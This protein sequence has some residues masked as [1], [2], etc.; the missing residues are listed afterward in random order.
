MSLSFLWIVTAGIARTANTRVL[1]E[2]AAI[3]HGEERT[4]RLNLRT[5][6]A[7]QFLRVAL[8]WIGLAVYFASAFISALLTSGDQ[9]HTAAFLFLFLAMFVT[10]AAI[11]SFFNWILLLAPIYALRDGLTLPRAMLGAWQL[12]RSR[13]GSLFGLNLAHLALRLVWFVFMS[14]VAAIPMGFVQILPKFVVFLAA[15]ASTMLYC[16]GA[17]LLFVARYAGYIEIAEQELHPSP[18]PSYAIPDLRPDISV[19]PISNPP[20]PTPDGG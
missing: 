12:T 2:R 20:Y 18:E 14:G 15:L 6:V 3:D 9:V 17:D 7:I 10:A 13:S 5:V 8:L 19:P 1:L 11:L 4:T 16:A